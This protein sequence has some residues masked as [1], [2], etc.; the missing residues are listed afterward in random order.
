MTTMN[1]TTTHAI[2]IGGSIAG[3]M[4]ARVLSQ[5]FGRVTVVERDALPQGGE[6]RNGAPQARHLHVLLARGQRIMEQYFP[7]FEHD[8]YHTGA[9]IIQGG[10]NNLTLTAAGW[11]RR[12]DAGVTLSATG[13]ASLEW[14]VRQRVQ[15]LPNVEFITETDVEHLLASED[16]SVITGVQL[17]SRRNRKG[18]SFA[19]Q[20]DFVVDASGRRSNTPEWLTE[21]GYAAPETTIVN[22][23]TGYATRWY[24][25]TPETTPDVAM[26][27]IQARPSEGLY[28]GGG[29][30]VVEGNRLVVTLLGANEDYPPTDEAGFM[31]FAKSLST[32]VLYDLIKTLTPEEPIY[33]YR[34]LQNQMRHYEKLA[35]RPENFIVIG[36]A[37]VAFNPIYGQGMSSAAMEAELLDKL[38]KKNSIQNL[39]GFAA[40]FQKKQVQLTKGAWLLSTGEDMRFPLVEGQLPGMQERIFHRYTDLMLSSMAYDTV[41]AHAFYQVLNLLATPMALMRPDIMLRVMWHSLR[42][43]QPEAQPTPQLR[44]AA[45][46]I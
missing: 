17:K 19:L 44:Q 11:I 5:H 21:L 37:A 33:A 20:G 38:L 31:E 10:L 28:R 2:V 24:K 45:A 29:Y 41:V 25:L 13:R 6:Y 8:I 23:H 14:L 18:D 16:G 7:G 40:K 43:R 32:P 46:N 9:P 4:T 39:R 26:L 30:L 35:R 15:A 34:G 3:L 36:D 12:F 42:H 1:S 22:A 27:A